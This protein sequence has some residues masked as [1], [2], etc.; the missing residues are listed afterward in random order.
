MKKTLKNII[1]LILEYQA[2]L[3]IRKYKPK[4][5]AVT[6]SVG[7]TSTKDAIYTVLST[8]YFV[9]KSEKSFNSE[10]GV[11]LTILGCQ[12]GWN[13]IIIWLENIV[14]GFWLIIAKHSYPEWLVLE[15]GADRPGDIQR[16]TKWL[17]PDISV[18]TRIGE[19]PVHVEFFKS[20]AELVEEK[21]Y[22]A[23]ALKQ[24]GVLILNGDDQDVIKFKQYAKGPVM[25][26]SLNGQGDMVA[27]NDAIYYEKNE[28]G[29]EMPAGITFKV[30][31]QGNSVPVIRKGALGLQHIFPTLYALAVGISQSMN[32][33]PISE[34][35][36]NEVLT[37]GRM[38][39]LKG[40]NGS[41]IID[42][43]YN[44]SPI[45]LHEAIKTLGQ[46]KVKGK[47]IA[48]LGDMLEL[49]KH[50]TEEHEKAGLAV[51]KVADILVTVGFRSRYIAEGALD[52]EMDDSKIQ[53]FDYAQEAGAYVD[54][55]LGEGDLL[56]I[57]GSQS[58]R[59][60]RVAELVLGEGQKKELV[61]VRQDAEWKKRT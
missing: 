23:R 48:V 58:M 39:L 19:M 7:K 17:K 3:V 59:M 36:S 14:K 22:L 44:S 38:R 31:F 11:P 28:K 27:S 4:I 12:N 60:E 53:Q 6:G 35:L 15:V 25:V 33:I 49:G 21:S 54:S 51:A 32:I 5:V 41:M 30:N 56:L 13:N 55:I 18:I 37:P 47:K 45:A 9:R 20:Q 26:V 1:V 46:I 50:S 24:G 34:A 2:K 29:E 40:K 16:I 61:L 10:I 57:K 42:D 43:T 52:G 8:S